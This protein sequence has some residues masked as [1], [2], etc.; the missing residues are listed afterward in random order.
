MFVDDHLI[1]SVSCASI[2]SFCILQ[3]QGGVN[4]PRSLGGRSCRLHFV[5]VVYSGT[6]VVIVLGAGEMVLGFVR[7]LAKSGIGR[8]NIHQFV[9][10]T[11]QARRYANVVL[12]HVLCVR[13][14]CALHW[15]PRQTLD[16][17]WKTHSHNIAS[18]SSCLIC[19]V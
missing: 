6:S 8:I 1:V 7:Q 11:W 17:L 4:K 9:D 18:E 10:I 16:H 15:Q 13:P 2:D 19:L 14:S 12:Y 5:L 3:A